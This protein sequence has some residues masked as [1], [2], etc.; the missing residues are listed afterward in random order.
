MV[1]SPTVNKTQAVER[2]LQRH[3]QLF[4]SA[5]IEDRR[6]CSVDVKHILSD[7]QFCEDWIDFEKDLLDEP[8]QTINC[9][10]LAIHQVISFL[11]F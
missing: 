2:Y 7:T 4:N 9:L 10:G 6:Y 8:E 3:Q 5:D 11:L 1:G